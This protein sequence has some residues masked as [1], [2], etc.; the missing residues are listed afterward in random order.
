MEEKDKVKEEQFDWLKKRNSCKTEF[1]LKTLYQT[2]IKELKFAHNSSKLNS[3]QSSNLT[4]TYKTKWGDILKIIQRGSKVDFSLFAQWS[5][6]GT[7]NTGEMLGNFVLKNNEGISETVT[8]EEANPKICKL[9]FKVIGKKIEIEQLG[10][11]FDC[12]FG[13]NVTATGT[14]IKRSSVT[15][16]L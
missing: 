4:G 2:R 1:C 15:P 7:T 12:G 8:S 16:K 6:D 9:K 13:W 14:Y 3:K 10:D 5:H 11:L